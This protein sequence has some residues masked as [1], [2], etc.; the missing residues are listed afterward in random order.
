MSL[1]QQEIN[2]AIRYAGVILGTGVTLMAT[3]GAISPE[4]SAA[5]VTNLQTV[6][7]DLQK[8][9]GDSWKLGVLIAPAVTL[10]LAKIGVNAGSPKSQ[11]ASVQAMPA[12]QVTVTDPKLA[13][14]IPGVIIDHGDAVSPQF[15]QVPPKQP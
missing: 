1:S 6:G 8:L 4:N 5:I 11:I 13:V 7:D 3:I 15:T 9:L 2:A 14:G 12:A 10:W